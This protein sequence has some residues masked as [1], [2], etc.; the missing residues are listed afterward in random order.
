MFFEIMAI[1]DWHSTLDRVCWMD[2]F[3]IYFM[4]TNKRKD[5]CHVEVTHLQ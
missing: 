2:M 5:N 4:T 3:R 1:G